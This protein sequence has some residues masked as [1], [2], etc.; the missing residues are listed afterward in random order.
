MGFEAGALGEALP[1]QRALVGFFSAVDHSVS[2]K[3]ALFGEAAA[4][5]HAA[6]GLLARVT[7]QV[8]LELT[9]PREAFAAVRAAEALLAEAGPPGGSHPLRQAE[10]AAALS[11]E[12]D[13][14]VGRCMAQ[15]WVSHRR[16]AVSVQML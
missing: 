2:D 6:E 3:V 5:L 10:V 8:L 7:P 9:E 11:E 14:G 12:G 4:A 15:V 16:S 1:A 13:G